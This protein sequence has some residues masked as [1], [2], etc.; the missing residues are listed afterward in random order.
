MNR[1]V[2]KFLLL[3]LVS[4]C[5]VSASIGHA[6]RRPALDAKAVVQDVIDGDTITLKK[7]IHGSREIRLVGIQAP[8]LP[9]GRKDFTA[10]PLSTDSKR[11][12]EKLVRRKTL[13]VTLDGRRQDRHGRLLAH[14]FDGH[15]WIQGEL[16]RLGMARVYSFPDNRSRVEAMLTLERD[17]R[18]AKRGIWADPFYA[19][20]SP[21]EAE[22]HIGTFQI[23]RGRVIDTAKVRTQVY[24]NFTADWRSDF[25]IAV[26]ARALRLFREA[27]VDP[28]T[29][30]GKVVQV[31]GWLRRRNGPMIEATH[32]EQIEMIGESSHD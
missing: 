18:A 29:F 13:T 5:L 30:K 11:A 2:T 20:R 1:F 6:A 31:R 22:K 21:K 8:K 19:I 17:A 32:P 14:L 10:W 7:K 16:L 27:G 28:L 26:R 25:T 12:L 3:F 15:T 24:I 4:A 23:V 9:L